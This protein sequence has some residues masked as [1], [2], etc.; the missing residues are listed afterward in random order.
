MDEKIT[1]DPEKAATNLAKHGLSFDSMQDLDWDFILDG[2]DT[3]AEGEHRW[4]AIGPIGE[5][6]CFLVYTND[7]DAIRVISLRETTNDEK[8]RWRDEFQ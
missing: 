3:S 1:W 4:T 5:R 2:E 8:R 7:G 6:L